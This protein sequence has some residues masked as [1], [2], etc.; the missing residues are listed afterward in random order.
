MDF[1]EC[2]FF[3]LKHSSYYIVLMDINQMVFIKA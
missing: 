1:I 3:L 2:L